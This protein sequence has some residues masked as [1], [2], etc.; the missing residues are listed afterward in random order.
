MLI[1]NPIGLGAGFFDPI[2]ISILRSTIFKLDAFWK[3]SDRS[4][5]ALSWGAIV[6]RL[7]GQLPDAGRTG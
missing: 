3:I 4:R 7:Y 5:F 6:L 2:F 1:G